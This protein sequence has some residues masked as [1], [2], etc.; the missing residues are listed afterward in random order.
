MVALVIAFPQMVMHYKSGAKQLD[1]TAVEEQ[2][3]NIAP[4]PDSFQIPDL[5]F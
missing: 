3:R 1:S 5:K 4:P 2:F